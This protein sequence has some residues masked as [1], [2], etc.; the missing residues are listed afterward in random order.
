MR[1]LAKAENLA[2]SIL[3]KVI[4][5]TKNDVAQNNAS[6]KMRKAIGMILSVFLAGL[7]IKESI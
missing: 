4:A 7:H 5:L 2:K 3:V 6:T 1:S